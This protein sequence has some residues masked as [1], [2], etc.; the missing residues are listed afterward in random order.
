MR[1]ITLEYADST[2]GA[3]EATQVNWRIAEFKL[4]FGVTINDTASYGVQHTFDDPA[5]YTDKADWTTNAVW[6]DH[7]TVNSVVDENADG[8]YAYPIQGVRLNV[9]A[10]TDTVTM[11][12]MQAS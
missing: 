12:I 3:T 2:T 6:F 1:P 5:E 7:E 4:G 10:N 8:N 11:K 9:T